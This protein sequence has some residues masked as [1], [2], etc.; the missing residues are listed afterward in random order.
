[1]PRRAAA[2]K[3]VR[4]SARQ[5]ESS[6]VPSDREDSSLMFGE[7]SK[8]RSPVKITYGGKAKFRNSSR[9]SNGALPQSP[10][11]PAGSRKS[12]GAH[13]RALPSEKKLRLRTAQISPARTIDS[14]SPLTESDSDFDLELPLP[15]RPS[16]RREKP[17]T[18]RKGSWKES[19][20]NSPLTPL[21]PSRT[22]LSTPKTTSSKKRPRPVTPT[23]ATASDS[24]NESALTPLPSLSPSIKSTGGTPT[25]DLTADEETQSHLPKAIPA[26]LISQLSSPSPSER[27]QRATAAPTTAVSEDVRADDA[28]SLAKLG[29]FVWLR[30]DNR[31]EVVNEGTESSD[32]EYWWPAK[33]VHSDG[34][35]QVSLYGESPRR[36]RV[37]DISSP[38]PANVQPVALSG[39]P[40]FNEHTYRFSKRPSNTLQS[41]R[42]KRKSDI[43]TRWKAARDQ[44]V[45]AEAEANDGL[46]MLLSG[47]VERNSSPPSP[48]RRSPAK[49]ASVV[50]LRASS[51]L[52]EEPVSPRK[53]WRA[54]SCDPTYD[55]PGELVLAKEKRGY[56]D[57]WPAQI[58]EYIKPTNPKQKPKFKVQY[59]D[60]IVKT[61]EK[62]MFFTAFEKGFKT[63][64]LGRD[65]YNYRMFEDADELTTSEMA[66]RFISEPV[67]DDTL[68]TPSPPPMLPPPASEDFYNL[69]VAEQFKYVNPVLACVIEGEYGPA[70]ERHDGFM[71]G[72][73]ARRKV[74]N[75]GYARGSLPPAQE[76]ELLGLITRWTRRRERRRELGFP[77]DGS[78]RLAVPSVNVHTNGE[79]QPSPADE[80][81]QAQEAAASQQSSMSISDSDLPHSEAEAPPSSYNAA[82]VVMED[83]AVRVA[84]PIGD[85]CDKAETF[86]SEPKPKEQAASQVHQDALAE[87]KLMDPSV[88]SAHEL[89]VQSDNARPHFADL[90]EVDRITYCGSVLLPEAVLQ[91][92]LWKAGQRTSYE[93]LPASEEQ[94]L[95]D[96]AVAKVNETYW[97]HD[98]IRLKRVAEGRLLQSDDRPPA[99]GSSV[100]AGTRSRPRRR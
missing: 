89:E 8:A 30:L 70:K 88:T 63:C 67:D 35:L 59:Y 3:A 44:M 42:K 7:P 26:S 38:S 72:G 22:K 53:A 98:I 74:C 33:I 65:Q 16:G 99:P 82:D 6:P 24:D 12:P 97:V 9:K 4:L 71:Q 31:G 94:R 49:K 17:S 84:S 40:R 52:S 5:L 1:M 96:I 50:E 48:V 41:P 56:S 19:S 25:I 32:E 81:T 86:P 75:S 29:T 37:V 91:L 60:G 73:N 27:I 46:P 11:A 85:A 76:E 15:T 21:T 20:K 39:L 92:V 93:L 95:H 78:S 79:G 57:Y 55:V 69:S 34:S 18:P 23:K 10:S 2:K 13:A 68:R 36:S 14:L 28:W 45:D 100:M 54:P 62:N 87:A 51:P 80:S 83:Q 77:L 58:L 61:I 47:Y 90:N 64:K 43:E 66:N